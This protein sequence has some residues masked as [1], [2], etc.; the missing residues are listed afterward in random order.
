MPGTSLTTRQ[1]ALIW[2]D[3]AMGTAG[4]GAEETVRVVLGLVDLFDEPAV[5][6]VFSAWTDAYEE[7]REHL[8]A[9]YRL[10]LE[11]V[12]E[13]RGVLES[14]THW[15]E[16]GFCASHCFRGVLG[17]EAGSLAERLR[18]GAPGRDALV[19]RVR[20]VLSVAGPVP[21]ADLEPVYQAVAGVPELRALTAA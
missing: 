5:T 3:M 6:S 17:N 14:L 10:R 4:P 15:F 19:R 7:T 12:G 8:W 18:P 11:A 20:R 1:S 13:P 2:A 21:R 16:D 9:A